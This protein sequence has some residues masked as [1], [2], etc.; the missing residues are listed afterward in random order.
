MLKT[1]LIKKM[2]EKKI[3]IVLFNVF[4]DIIFILVLKTYVIITKKLI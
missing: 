4:K 3:L 1:Y 2:E